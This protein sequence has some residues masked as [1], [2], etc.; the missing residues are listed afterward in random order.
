MVGK[1]AQQTN[2]L[3][4]RQR[5]PVEDGGHILEHCGHVDLTA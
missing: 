2:D 4:V 1:M 3:L 5:E